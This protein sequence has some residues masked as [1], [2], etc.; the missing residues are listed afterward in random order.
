MDTTSITVAR[1]NL[2]KLAQHTIDSHEPITLTG[3][4][5]NVVMLSLED[6]EALQETVY[7]LQ[8]MPSIS[9]E[10]KKAKSAKKKDL[11]GRDALPW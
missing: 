9:K 11:Y 5:G 2:Y 6:Y 1:S 7:I 10:A 4:N 3:K 8:T